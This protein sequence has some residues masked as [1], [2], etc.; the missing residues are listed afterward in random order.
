[1]DKHPLCYHNSLDVLCVRVEVHHSYT[2]RSNVKFVIVTYKPLFLIFMV[3]VN[4]VFYSL[5][6]KLS[7]TYPE[8][9]TFDVL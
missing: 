8:R 5:K 3:N 7:Y 2:S 9:T 4:E 1:M 6:F